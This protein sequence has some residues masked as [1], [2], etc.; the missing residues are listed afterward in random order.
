MRREARGV[1]GDG[2]RLVFEREEQ[3]KLRDVVYRLAMFDDRRDFPFA[4]QLGE[5]V[6]RGCI[7]LFAANCGLCDQQKKDDSNREAN[8]LHDDLPVVRIATRRSR[9]VGSSGIGLQ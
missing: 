7:V 6:L 3:T 1:G 2:E 8:L 4:L 9:F 5:F